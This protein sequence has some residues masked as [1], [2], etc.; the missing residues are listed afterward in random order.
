MTKV[1]KINNGEIGNITLKLAQ[2]Y[3]KSF[4]NG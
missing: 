1:Y 3:S 4:M 2:M